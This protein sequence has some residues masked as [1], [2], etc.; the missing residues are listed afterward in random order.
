MGWMWPAGHRFDSSGIRYSII[1]VFR[2]YLD[3]LDLLD[4]APD[5]FLGDL[6]TDLHPLAVAGSALG[7]SYM[8]VHT[9]T[10]PKSISFQKS[11]SQ[12]GR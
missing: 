12:F 7:S 2:H 9:R 4:G 10:A 1:T 11:G 6:L 3:K 5:E 8:H